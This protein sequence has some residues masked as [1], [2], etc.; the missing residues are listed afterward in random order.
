MR[1]QN[2]WDHQSIFVTCVREHPPADPVL[3]H[4]QVQP[5]ADVAARR[6]DGYDPCRLKCKRHDG[7]EEADG[8]VKRKVVRLGRD[9]A[10]DESHGRYA[11]LSQEGA[12]LSL[13]ETAEADIRMDVWDV[14]RDSESQGYVQSQRYS[15]HVRSTGSSQ[16]TEPEELIATPLVTLNGSLQW[17]DGEEPHSLPPPLVLTELSSLLATSEPATGRAPV[18]QPT[19]A[20]T[21]IGLVCTSSPL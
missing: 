3:V 9:L 14:F 2:A 21:S 18:R 7:V 5:G 1:L 19:G 4:R 8:P 6:R 12:L 17:R 13:D 20:D 15:Q 11:G 16:D 10:Q